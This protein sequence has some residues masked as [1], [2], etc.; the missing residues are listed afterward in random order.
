[1]RATSV[2][3][4]LLSAN[5]VSYIGVIQGNTGV[6]QELYRNYTV[7]IQG[8]YR[9]YTGIIHWEYRSYTGIIGWE[10]RSYT[11]KLYTGGIQD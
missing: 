8:E 5:L 11:G 9:S 10:Y 6:I 2:R 3:G 4:K 7:V 1:M